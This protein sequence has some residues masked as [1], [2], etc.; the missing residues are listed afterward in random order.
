MAGHLEVRTALTFRPM[1]ETDL[2]RVMENE[3]RSYAYPWTRG[4]FLD[5]LRAQNECWVAERDTILIGHGVLSIAAGEGHLLNV[6]VRR[7]QQGQGLGRQVVVHMLARACAA[8]AV[9]L[10]LEVRPS[11]RVA[12]ALYAS[13]GFSEIGLRK[14]YYP[15]SA[16]SE[17][18]V[19][20]ALPL[21]Q[22]GRPQG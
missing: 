2:D 13:L 15:A 7:D 5:C 12:R 8:G 9:R 11:N 10:F 19:V 21:T 18:A 20:L 6:C 1:R 17:D 3:T 22:P 4:V 16:G 14:G